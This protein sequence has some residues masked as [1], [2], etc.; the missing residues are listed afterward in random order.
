MSTFE[1]RRRHVYVFVY[2]HCM[3]VITKDDKKT[4]QKPSDHSRNSLSL[5]GTDYLLHTYSSGGQYTTHSLETQAIA[6]QFDAALR[7]FLSHFTS[8]WVSF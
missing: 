1:G 7:A 5:E 6:S 2:V 4:I 8:L 3:P